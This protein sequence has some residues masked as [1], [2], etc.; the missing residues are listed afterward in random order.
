MGTVKDGGIASCG[1]G[2]L[3][4]TYQD[5]NKN[6][7]LGVEDLFYVHNGEEGDIIVLTYTKGTSAKICDV[8]LT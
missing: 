3:N 4:I 8:V 1:P 7:K 6:K 5:V 2:K